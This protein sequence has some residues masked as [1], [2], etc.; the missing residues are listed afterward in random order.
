MQC[1]LLLTVA[2]TAV[3]AARPTAFDSNITGVWAWTCGD[4]GCSHCDFREFQPF[5]R[6]YPNYNGGIKYNVCNATAVCW[7]IWD[8]SNSCEGRPDSYY[9]GAINQCI[10]DGVWQCGNIDHPP[11]WHGGH[12]KCEDRCTSGSDCS[13]SGACTECVRGRCKQLETRRRNK[14][15]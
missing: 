1:A 3:F 6:C 11:H 4:Q 9:C 12:S 13:F 2:A 14:S 10:G 15:S 5:G 7:Q 8:N